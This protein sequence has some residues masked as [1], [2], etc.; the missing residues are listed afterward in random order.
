[1]VVVSPTHLQRLF[2][3]QRLFLAGFLLATVLGKDLE[4]R[5]AWDAGCGNNCRLEKQILLSLLL[6]AKS[7][8]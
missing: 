3:L 5:A 8:V 6:P 2:S 4:I 7:N 1:M